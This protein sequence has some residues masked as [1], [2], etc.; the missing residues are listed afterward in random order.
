MQIFHLN[1]QLFDFIHVYKRINF[2]FGSFNIVIII[3]IVTTIQLN[4]QIM[5][6]FICNCYK[7]CAFGLV[8][9]MYLETSVKQIQLFIKWSFEIIDII[10][11]SEYLTISAVIVIGWS[12]C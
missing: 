5:S 2:I 7:F 9:W 4:L 11:F 6:I 3:I 1:K 10:C 12:M 8:S